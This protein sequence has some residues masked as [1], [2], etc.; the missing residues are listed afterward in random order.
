M[1]ENQSKCTTQTATNLWSYL[2]QVNP[3]IP[4]NPTQKPIA[5]YSTDFYDDDDV[6]I[7]DVPTTDVP[8]TD[9][10]I[11]TNIIDDSDSESQTITNT[12]VICQ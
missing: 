10:P 1:G 2:R 9:V 12:G 5:K 11:T 6:P 7:T 3:S 4:I 8:T